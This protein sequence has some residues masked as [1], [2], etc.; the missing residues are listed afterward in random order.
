MT[1]FIIRTLLTA[2]AFIFVLPH[3]GFHFTGSFGS[4]VGYAVLFA[5]VAFFVD[6]IAF[7]AIGAFAVATMGLGLLLGNIITWIVATFELKA[8]CWIFPGHFHND[9]FGWTML[10]A[11]VMLVIGL[12]TRPTKS[13]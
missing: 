1:R 13:K 10:A 2:V 8:M 7:L 5:I 3:L 12:I 11:L 4:A 9:G 6:I